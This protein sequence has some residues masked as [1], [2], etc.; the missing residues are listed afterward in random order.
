MDSEDIPLNLSRELLQ[1]SALIAYVFITYFLVNCF[2]MTL[3]HYF[4]IIIFRKL[5]HVLTNR[6]L[7]FMVD[8]ASKDPVGYD[9][10]Y[11]DYS[12]FFKEGIVTGQSPLEKV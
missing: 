3:K 12:L 2:F 9:A 7:K 8:M 10:F 5:R 4:L 11:K 6:F 1:N